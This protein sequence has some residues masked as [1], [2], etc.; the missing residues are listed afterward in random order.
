MVTQNEMILKHLKDYKMVNQNIAR[1]LYGC[2]RLASRINDLRNNGH[3]I[4][5]E[6]IKTTNRFGVKCSYAN[7]KFLG[8]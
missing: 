6:T 1:E 3:N 8:E 4:L 2:N 5:T 7:Y